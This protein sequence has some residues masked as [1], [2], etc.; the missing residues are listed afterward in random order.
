MKIND[1]N[2]SEEEHLK[3]K[4]LYRAKLVELGFVKKKNISAK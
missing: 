3:I 4:R 2:F 1:D